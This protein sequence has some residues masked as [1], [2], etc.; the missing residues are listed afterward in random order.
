MVSPEL[1][2]LRPSPYDA[3]AASL[4]EHTEAIGAVMAGAARL[5]LGPFNPPTELPAGFED[6]ALVVPTS[7]ST[8]AAKAVA[9][10]RR[11]L[12]ASQDATASLIGH[13]LWLPLLPATHI[14]GVQVIARA[15]RTAQRLG[16]AA[17][18]L[19]DPLPDL[20]GHFDSAAFAA[21][22]EPALAQADSAVLPALTSLVPTQL[23]R[24]VTGTTGADARARA[25]LRRFAAVL[26]GGAATPPEVLA[27]ARGQRI[28][29]RTTYGSSE[30]AGGCVYDGAP[31]PGVRLRVDAPDAEGAGRLVITSPTL[32]L[33]YLVADGSGERIGKAFPTSDLA[34]LG[35]GGELSVLG[36]AD[37]VIITGGRKVLPQDV[38]RAIDRSLMLGGLVRAAVVVGVPDAEWGQRVEALVTLDPAAPAEPAEVS[39]LVRSALRTTEVPSFMIPRRVHVVGDLPLLGIG[40]IDRSA[41]ARIAAG[42]PAAPGA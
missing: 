6:T 19:P 40:K 20:R 34:S 10:T 7:G 35:P 31:L 8:G 24:I 5:W 23:T 36:R 14:A 38:E 32:A 15:H 37:D 30:T 21:L 17:P 16:L 1:P 4:A 33:G 42:H 28:A 41:A 2:W 13:G 39:A 29:V 12:L 9:L 3:S 18:A 11:A 25:L 22:A 27:R 26:V